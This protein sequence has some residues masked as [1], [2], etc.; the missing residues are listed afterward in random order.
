MP[1]IFDT[2][3]AEVR[4]TLNSALPRLSPRISESGATPGTPLG[5]AALLDRAPF[6]AR[7][8]EAF[9]RG[10]PDQGPVAVPVHFIGLDSLASGDE[11]FRGTVRR[12]SP[13]LWTNLLTDESGRLAALAD[14]NPTSR[15]LAA[16]SEGPSILAMG[17][18]L[19]NLTAEEH[20][21]P[22]RSVAMLRIP[23]LHLSAIWLKGA[24]PDQ[25]DIVIP[26]PGP[27]Q[28]LKAGQRYTMAE[29]LTIVRPMA[30]DRI[31]QTQETSGG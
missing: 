17:A 23:A 28:P 26:S 13:Q 10:G 15:T 21:S 1:L 25:Q 4:E 29:F 24:D 30:A 11:N 6:I 2:P 7:A 18:Q 14:V 5:R 20:D 12:S 19:E 31:R 27:I 16:L 9:L 8:L 22:D 3:P